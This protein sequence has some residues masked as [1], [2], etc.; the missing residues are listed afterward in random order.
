MPQVSLCFFKVVIQHPIIAVEAT[1]QTGE[2]FVPAL[3][4][5]NGRND[6]VVVDGRLYLSSVG[7]RPV[8][9]FLLLRK[10]PVGH[11]IERVGNSDA[12]RDAVIGFVVHHFFAGQL[13]AGTCAFAGHAHPRA[14]F[15]VLVPNPAAFE[16]RFTGCLRMA[17]KCYGDCFFAAGMYRDR[18]RNQV[19]ACFFFK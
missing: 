5:A 19:G 16:G 6:V 13:D 12:E 8:R 10:T 3:V 2:S 14:S 11:G 17:F 15:S 18:K 1:L 7:G 9:V 4:F